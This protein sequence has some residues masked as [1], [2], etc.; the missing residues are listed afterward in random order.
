LAT[1]QFW[2]HN[3]GLLA[4]MVLLVAFLNGSKG[5]DPLIGLASMVIALSVILFAVNVFQRVR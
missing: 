2:L 1:V 4:A 5:L 3:A